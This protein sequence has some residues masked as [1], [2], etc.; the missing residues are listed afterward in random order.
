MVRGLKSASQ[1]TGHIFFGA[2]I[3]LSISDGGGSIFR[4]SI[5]FYH[6]LLFPLCCQFLNAHGVANS[7]KSD[8]KGCDLQMW[9]KL[10]TAH[11]ESD[12]NLFRKCGRRILSTSQWHE[13]LSKLDDHRHIIVV[14][15][16]RSSTYHCGTLWLMWI[17][18]VS[19]FF[20]SWLFR[21]SSFLQ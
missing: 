21:Y 14:W 7:V 10:P 3:L 18:A 12:W 1:C 20:G 16:K 13:T 6:C 4:K 19:V 17:C 15:N 9:Q 5:I 11:G 2:K 8:V